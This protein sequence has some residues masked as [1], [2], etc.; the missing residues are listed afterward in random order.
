VDNMLSDV[1]V[2]KLLREA[3]EATRIAILEDKLNMILPIY[4]IK[5]HEWLAYNNDVWC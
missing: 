5:W 2:S 4:G 3:H 1:E